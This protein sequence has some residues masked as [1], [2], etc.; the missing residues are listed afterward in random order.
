MA[1]QS[2]AYSIF[3]RHVKWL[4]TSGWVTKN[5]TSLLKLTHSSKT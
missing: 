1:N 5:P 3:S 2:E 4:Q